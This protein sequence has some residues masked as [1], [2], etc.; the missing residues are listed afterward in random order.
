MLTQ[1]QIDH[2]FT[3]QPPTPEQT[4]KYKAIATASNAVEHSLKRLDQRAAAGCQC[5]NGGPDYS[6]EYRRI[7]DTARALVESF[8]LNCPPSADLAAAIRCARLV[9]N[10]YNMYVV[11]LA[12]GIKKPYLLAIARDELTKAC[13][14]ANASIALAE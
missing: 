3:Y 8:V 14:Q 7:N 12:G 9:R 4:V 11:G 6:E 1:A 13:W 5:C 10:A 2:M